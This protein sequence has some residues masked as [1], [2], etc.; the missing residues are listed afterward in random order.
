[1]LPLS[2]VFMVFFKSIH[3]GILLVAWWFLKDYLIEF[4]SLHYVLLAIGLVAIF[5]KGVYDDLIQLFFD[6]LVII[7]WGGFMR[8][9]CRGYLPGNP[10]RQKMLIS[11]PIE[12]FI[13]SPAASIPNEFR[14]QYDEI[15]DLLL[16][17][18][19]PGNEEILSQLLDRYEQNGLP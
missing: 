7:T 15:M 9:I 3:I 14:M 12:T 1:M 19:Q 6:I 18:N 13:A 5:Y 10:F 17:I 2:W 11:K 4:G 16:D 8:W